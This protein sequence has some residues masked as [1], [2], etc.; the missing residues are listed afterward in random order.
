MRTRAARGF[1]L[2]ELMVAVAIVG[3]LVGIAYPAY[4]DSVRKSRRGQA[5][6]DLLELAQ[7]AERFHTQG[8]SYVGFTAS[9]SAADLRSP[10]SGTPAYSLRVSGETANSFVLEAAPAGAQADDTACATLSLNQAG[11]KG[12]TGSSGAGYCW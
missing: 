8:N 10:R 7:R 5:K 1:T 11:V 12:A 2:I 3:I 4:L 6:A 9:L